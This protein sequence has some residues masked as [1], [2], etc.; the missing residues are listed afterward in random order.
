MVPYALIPCAFF[1]K[2]CPPLYKL[3]LEKVNALFVQLLILIFNMLD[4]FILD[5]HFV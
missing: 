4:I 5:T 1:L 2:V 3:K